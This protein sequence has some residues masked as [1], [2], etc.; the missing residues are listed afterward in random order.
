M[1]V[2]SEQTLS[3]IEATYKAPE[4]EGIVDLYFYRKI[5]FWLAQLFA[6]LKATPTMVTL[7][8]GLLG[9]T[10]G[11][12]Y[13]YRDLRVNIVGMVL[14]VGA[15][16]LDNADG[17]LARLTQQASREGRIVDSLVDHFVFL[18]IYL[19]LTLRYLVTGASP[20]I[21]FLVVAA[22]ISHAL[23][24]AAADYCRI[25]YIYFLKGGSRSD[26]DTSSALQ[27]SYRELN[28]RRQAWN[29]F[30][31]ALHLNYTR[32]QELLLPG[33]KRLRRTAERL[34]P[35][36]MPAWLKTSYREGAKP[37]FKWWGLLMTN[38]RMFI[39]FAVLFLGQPV[40][41]FWIEL[42]AFN[43]LLVYLV[44][45]QQKLNCYRNLWHRL[46]S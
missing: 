16:A 22:G 46:K 4:V 1:P 31:L 34:F 2:Q 44:F 33:L 19:H 11:H 14:H 39:L 23:Q 27:A 32:Q 35:A 10:A 40:W 12:L 21:C 42:T 20:T 6:K 25:A 18:S 26:F 45:R 43:V 36:E 41:Y 8:G 5:G 37:M 38:T 9:V 28:W 17:Q 29:K 24:A 30:L 7:L 13:Y 3:A 15:N